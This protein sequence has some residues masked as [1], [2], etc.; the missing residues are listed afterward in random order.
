[1]FV[2]GSIV[3]TGLTNSLGLKAPLASPSFTGSVISA[4]DVSLNAGLSVAS[5]SSFNSNLFIGGSI[6]NT[7][8]TSALALKAPLAAPSFTGVVISAGDVSLNARLSVALDSSFNANLFVSGSIVNTGLT[9]A[10]GLKAPLESP[11][12]TGT[13]SAPTAVSGTNTTQIATTQ[14][15]RSE[16]SALVA[17]A[18]AALDTL[19]ELATALGN[20]A[21]F[22]TTITN[23]I[24]LKAPSASPSFTGT[25]L[26]SSADASFNGNVYVGGSIINT[27]LTNSLGLKAPLAAP[28]FTGLIVSAGDVSLN[29][30]LSVAS[31]SSFNSNLFIGGNVGIGAGTANTAYKLDVCGNMRIFESVGT[32]ASAT[33]GSLIFEHADLSG[34]SSIM[35][36]SKNAA[37]DYAYIQYEEN[38]GNGNSGLSEKGVL[39][40][41]IENDPSLNIIKDTISLYP[42][43]GQGYVGINTKGPVRN[44]DISG[45]MAVSGDV[46]LNSTV[47]AKYL[48]NSF[49]VSTGASPGLTV[50]FPISRT[51]LLTDSASTNLIITLPTLPTSSETYIV[52]FKRTVYSVTSTITFNTGGATANTQLIYPSHTSI[53]NGAPETQTSGNA[54][55]YDA[56]G[57]GTKHFNVITLMGCNNGTVVGWFEM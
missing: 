20:D 27:G 3:N 41:G 18:P 57:A 53:S 24:G 33:Q 5:D 8:L 45:S 15:V 36:K 17:S 14:Y 50:T 4:G 54:Y 47:F 38:G 55:V 23:S 11:A 2:G 25:F 26:V 6:V 44:L 16:I 32:R 12:L 56:G 29:S 49:I 43:A 42:C 48:T 19:N 10:L 28:S 30:R 22:S 7:G 31:D 37:N 51:Y 35:F 21:A 9:S 39:I 46:S 1:M 40:L 52:T 13:P 34:V